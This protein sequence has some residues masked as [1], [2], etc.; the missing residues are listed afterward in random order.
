ML[1]LLARRIVLPLLLALPLLAAG[2]GCSATFAVRHYPEFYDPQIRNVAVV[3]F[4]N[5]TPSPQA[6]QF[7]AERLAEALRVNGTYTVTGPRE[8]AAKLAE[9]KVALPPAVDP[10]AWA[11]TLRKAGLTGE[12]IFGAVRG[13]SSDRST[14][15]VAEDYWD[16]GP[17]W[18]WR[19]QR[20][21]GYGYGGGYTVYRQYTYVDGYAAAEASMF[22]IADGQTVYA[23][24]GPLADRVRCGEPC[25]TTSGQAVMV[26]TD[27]LAA[28]MVFVFAVTPME[29]EVSKSDTLRTARK[30]EDGQW[31]FTSDFPVA[32]PTMF[33]I[34]RLPQ[35]AARNDFR[36]VVARA[37][38][39]KPAAEHVFQWG[40]RDETITI[41]FEPA[42]VAEAGGGP[43]AYEVRLYC[44]GNFV[45]KQSIDLEP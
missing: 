6:G 7:V 44:N 4:A 9:A 19:H 33:V 27:R 45:L 36:V 8:V 28:K 23:M 29:L 35:E 3:P 15:V 21:Y 40:P 14:Y 42:K 20:G 38:D 18:G 1:R 34:V 39:P 41:G 24:P 30:R 22:H 26:A 13:F 37:K 16:E 5:S 12:F 11:E 43:G 25:A 2:A 31:K 10:K 32:G 17:G